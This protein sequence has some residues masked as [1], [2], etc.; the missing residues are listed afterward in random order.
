MSVLDVERG[1][2]ARYAQRVLS[3]PDLPN[4]AAR[5]VV[6]WLYERADAMSLPLP[7]PLA[8]IVRNTYTEGYNFSAFETSFKSTRDELIATLDPAARESQRPEP[9]A[10][11]VESLVLAL[12]IDN[13]DT[14]WKIVGLFACCARFDQVQFFAN[15]VQEVASPLARTVALM[16]GEPLRLVEECLSP[17]SDL[18]A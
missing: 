11:N 1:L 2:I 8:M 13:P 5:H 12:N 14:A 6:S 10:G 3:R 17:A 18:I 15:A 16:T 9:L 7:P 4:R